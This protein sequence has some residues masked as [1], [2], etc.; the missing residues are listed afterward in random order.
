MAEVE[1]K[2]YLI[3]HAES[4]MNTQAHLIGGRSNETPLTGRGVAQALKL[5][6]YLI[7]RNIRPD[8]I[9]ASPAVRTLETAEFSLRT[10]G[11]NKKPIIHDELQEL[12][13]GKWVGLHREEVYTEEILADIERLGKD[14]KGDGGESMNDVGNRMFDWA[15]EICPPDSTEPTTIFA[16][17]HGL[18]IRCLASRIQNWSQR[19]TYITET[20]NASISLFVFRDGEW[21]LNYLGKETQ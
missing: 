19:Q 2:L 18:A 10:M 12:D 9:Y 17:T 11:I 1:T 13:Q 16:Y 20:P 8:I 5:G 6:S 14:F 4:V 3:R 7:K 15:T 21:N